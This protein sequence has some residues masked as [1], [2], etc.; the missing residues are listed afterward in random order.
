MQL[1]ASTEHCSDYTCSDTCNQFCHQVPAQYHSHRHNRHHWKDSSCCHKAR[2]LEQDASF[3]SSVSAWSRCTTRPLHLGRSRRL[4]FSWLEREN[5]YPLLAP[6]AEDLVS[7]PSS[8]AYVER[9]ISACGDMY[10]RKRNKACVSRVVL[11]MKRK[12][13][14]K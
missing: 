3:S 4:S 13:L 5:L 9:V 2:Y 7:A 8:Q 14:Q 12:F 11:K 6:V 10:T 1:I